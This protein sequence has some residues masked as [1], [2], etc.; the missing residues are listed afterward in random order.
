M[1]SEIRFQTASDCLRVASK[2]SSTPREWEYKTNPLHMQGVFYYFCSI[3]TS[4]LLPVIT[5]YAR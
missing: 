1:P 3:E 2:R 4:T 5:Q